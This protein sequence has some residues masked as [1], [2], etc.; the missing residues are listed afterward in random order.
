MLN[1][2]NIQSGYGA[3]QVLFD[4]SLNAKAGEIICIMGR[5][6][7]GKTTT[8]KT[9]MG[10]LPLSAGKITLNGTDLSSIT[11]HRIS[12][13]GIAY[14]PQGRR[15]FSEL[16]VA[17]NLEVGLLHTPDKA[18]TRE[19]LLTLFPRLRDRLKQQADTLSGGEQQML[20]M[21]R[22]LAIKP[23]VLLLDEPTE[24]LQPSMIDLIRD[25]VIKMKEQKLAVVLVEQRVDAVLNIADQVVFVEN[26]RGLETTDT[27]ALRAEPEK[28]YRYL[29][30]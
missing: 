19:E 20:A 16:S 11:P 27:E 13:Q 30:V 7:A 8:L 23:S 17:Q 1:L 3:V 26:G 9:I 28:L 12:Q 14:V 24:G 29:G 21:A 2:Q 6:G 18:Q 15:L 10:L 22:A 25:V 5:N 4:L